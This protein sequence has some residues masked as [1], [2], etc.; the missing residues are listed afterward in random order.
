VAVVE[1]VE[2]DQGADE[3]FRMVYLELG[4]PTDGG[5]SRWA[6]ADDALSFY[7]GTT[8]WRFGDDSDI[9]LGILLVLLGATKAIAL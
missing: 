3:A 7:I 8:R 1:G 9:C 2:E 5:K 6:K 4:W